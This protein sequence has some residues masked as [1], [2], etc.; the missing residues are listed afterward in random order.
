[1]PIPPGLVLT[2]AFCCGDVDDSL[3]TFLVFRDRSNEPV[4][5]SGRGL[6]GDIQRMFDF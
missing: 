5:R 2:S 4:E 6:G 3:M 1:M